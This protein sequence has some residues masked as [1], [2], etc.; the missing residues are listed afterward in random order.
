MTQC[1]EPPRKMFP[2]FEKIVQKAEVYFMT[3]LN[4]L[5]TEMA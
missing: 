4:I 3:D 5:F 2:Q 1:D